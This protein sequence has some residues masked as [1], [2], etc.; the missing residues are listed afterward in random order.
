MLERVDEILNCFT[1]DEPE[2]S[3]TELSQETNLNKSTVFRILNTLE[4]LGWIKRDCKSGLYRLGLGLFELGSQAV[5]GLDFY[6][7]SRPHLEKLV[8]TTGQTVHLGIH[9]DGQVLYINKLE[10]PDAFV[11]QP[12]TIGTKLPLHCTAMGKV[13]LAFSV[14]KENAESVIS[15]YELTRF[16]ENTITEKKKLLSELEE[17]RSKGYAFDNEEV[18]KGL[19]CVAAPVRDYTCKAIA[20]ISVSG[21]SLVFD[22]QYISFLCDEVTRTANQISSNL[23][24]RDRK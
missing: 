9:I 18:Q 14:E 19:C 21:L 6:N 2:K 17:I 20:A 23:G 22:N 16:T 4:S 24:C 7:I 5:K 13:L 8:K 3:L 12:S 1:L 11:A 15:K 10:S